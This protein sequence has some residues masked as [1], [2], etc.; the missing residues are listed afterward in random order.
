[1]QRT[2]KCLFVH[3]LFLQTLQTLYQPYLVQENVNILG[4]NTFR[5]ARLVFFNLYSLI[6]KTAPISQMVF[7]YPHPLDYRSVRQNDYVWVT[8]SRPDAG[9]TIHHLLEAM[10]SNGIVASYK[11]FIHIV[12]KTVKNIVGDMNFFTN[13]KIYFGR[14]ERNRAWYAT[15]HLY[16]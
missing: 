6:K 4:N 14:A 15:I 12:H 1:M 13:K 11:K 2:W 10:P 8:A 7:L 9:L 5:E 3:F 16:V